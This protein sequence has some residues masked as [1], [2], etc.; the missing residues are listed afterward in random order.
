MWQELLSH[1]AIDTVTVNLLREHRWPVP[2]PYAAFPA[3]RGSVV[4]ETAAWSASAAERALRDLDP[5]TIVFITPRAFHPRLVGI[6]RRSILDFQD[7]FS[8]SYSSRAAVDTRPGAALGW[9]LLSWATARFEARDHG[10]LTVA[11]GWSEAVQ[12]GATWIPNTVT[13]IPAA[14]INDHG[15]APV[16]LL[17][18]GKLSAL[19][20]V[21]A[22]RR[23]GSYWPRLTSERPSVSAL[24]AGAYPSREVQALA[25]THGWQVEVDFES[26]LAVCQRARVALVP[27]RHANGIQNK[28]LEA[29]AA[30]LPQVVSAAALRGMKPGFP[31]MIARSEESTVKAIDLLLSNPSC[32]LELAYA[33]HAH[34]ERHYSIDRWA[35]VVH[36]LVS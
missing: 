5:D 3:I 17:F 8:A 22:L 11:A 13:T 7:R 28:V 21:D 26:V 2:S 34:V 33:A 30:G 15:A 6:A 19:P 31:A 32:R 4:P 35:P 20:N 10:V 14:T 36:D 27:L 18:F 1:A 12:V 25:R 23:I 24:I 16:D 29:A 9:R